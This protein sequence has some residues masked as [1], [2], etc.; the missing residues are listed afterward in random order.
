MVIIGKQKSKP[1]RSDHMRIYLFDPETGIYLGEDFAD[2]PLFQGDPP[3][4][5]P[6][7]T[8][9]APPPYGRGEVPVFNAEEKRWELRPLSSFAVMGETGAGAGLSQE[10]QLSSGCSPNGGITLKSVLLL[11]ITLLLAAP[12]HATSYVPLVKEDASAKEEE[13]M[14][15]GSRVLLFHSGTQDV[16]NAIKLTDVLTA[17]RE[18]PASAP[19]SAKET[20]KIRVIAVLDTYHLEGEVI[21]GHA[22]PGYLALKDT[23]ACLV[24]RRL[25]VKQ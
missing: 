5:P 8:T 6:D 20:G 23:A 2:P 25:K 4:V 15:A 7:A 16:K 21:E 18:Y 19:G 13:A 24:T 14:T 17:Y 3:V 22:G 9:I 11:L 1:E 12:L 10:R